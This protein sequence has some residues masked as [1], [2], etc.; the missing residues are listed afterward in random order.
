MRAEPEAGGTA[1]LHDK[2]FESRVA[3]GEVADANAGILCEHGRRKPAAHARRVSAQA[4]A[5]IVDDYPGSTA[6][7]DDVGPCELCAASREERRSADKSRK[8]QREAEG[9]M[10]ARLRRGDPLHH[11]GEFFC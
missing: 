9:V 6:L 1:Y 7:L 4:W 8:R 3:S 11:L 5:R 2:H 10:L